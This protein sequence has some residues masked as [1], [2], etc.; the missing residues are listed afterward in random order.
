V[1]AVVNYHS[2]AQFPTPQYP[3]MAK[4]PSPYP[5]QNHQDIFNAQMQAQSVDMDRY[6]QKQRDEYESA[7]S[8]AQRELALN[9]LSQMY[10]ARG[11]ERDL[12]TGRMRMLLE[13]LL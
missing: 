4:Q 6:A 2:N 13:G 9:G 8:Q 3:E 11:N 1:Q 10:Q 7:A 12:Q 5:G